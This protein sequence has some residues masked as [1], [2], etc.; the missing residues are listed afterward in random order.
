MKKETIKKRLL[1][2][3]TPLM[4]V[5]VC[6]LGLFGS[7]VRGENTP[8][9]DI[10]ILIDFNAGEETYL[11]YINA[12]NLL[13]DAFGKTK[14]DVVTKKGLSPYIGETILKEVEYV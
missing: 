10:D 12:C 5:G 7:T 3:K 14:L 9:S 8:K 6:Q 1:A 13:Q 2:L 11:N 4:A